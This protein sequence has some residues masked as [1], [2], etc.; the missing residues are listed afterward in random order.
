MCIYAFLCISMHSWGIG[1]HKNVQNGA[2]WNKEQHI[3]AMATNDRSSSHANLKNCE[4]SCQTLHELL[5]NLHL[6]NC[7]NFYVSFW[8]KFSRECQAPGPERSHSQWQIT[9]IQQTLGPH[10]LAKVQKNAV[11]SRS[12]ASAPR[13]VVFFLRPKRSLFQSCCPTFRSHIHLSTAAGCYQTHCQDL[14]LWFDN[15]DFVWFDSS[16]HQ[17]FA[18]ASPSKNSKLLNFSAENEESLLEIFHKIIFEPL[19]L[20]II[21]FLWMQFKRFWL[22][23]RYAWLHPLAWESG[24][25]FSFSSSRTALM[26]RPCTGNVLT[27][28]PESMQSTIIKQRKKKKNRKESSYSS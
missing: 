18:A 28:V 25:S 8:F 27:T 16:L 14:S 10:P 24:S 13:F 19:P 6:S 17:L 26:L 3:T 1:A 22:R 23:I 15:F 7:M 20:C 9:K 2:G 4:M 21:T 12:S 11:F 5:S